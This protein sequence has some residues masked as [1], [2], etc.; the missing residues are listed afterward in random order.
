MSHLMQRAA[1]PGRPRQGPP[2]RGGVAAATGGWGAV[3]QRG[4]ALLTAM[5]IVSLVATLAAGMVWQQW[6]AVQV[7]SAE[8]GRS[9]S[10][11]ILDGAVDWARLIL[12]EDARTGGPDHLGEPWAVP[13]AEAKLS[14]F[15]AADRDNTDDAPD[16]FLSG[17]IADAQSRY[18]L[19]HLAEAAEPAEVAAEEAT[20][21]R[22][23]EFA[24]ASGDAAAALAR[25]L[26]AA[27]TAGSGSS[28]EGA[29]GDP[30]LM[31]ERIEDLGWLGVD[32]DTLAR[33][34]PYVTLLPVR[35]A[36]NV[37]TAPK[38]VIAAVVEGLDLAS[39]ERLVQQR[40]SRPFRNLGEVAA[41]L[42]PDTPLDQ[43]RLGIASS[44]FEV[45]GRLRLLDRAV[46]ERALVERRNLEVVALRRERASGLDAGPR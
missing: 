32:T 15:L 1:A 42:P 21:R 9:Q 4:A 12:R 40:Q 8:R 6:R 23:F 5:L 7:E 3:P 11:W 27:A 10:Q 20:L 39:A 28:G 33:I 43:R 22:L 13:L 18:N 46:E 31:P 38:E 30:A 35:T 16:A 19:R 36:V 44:F 37:N 34:A 29:Q 45:R 25:A 41:Q 14:T 26:R 2:P 17:A 24:G